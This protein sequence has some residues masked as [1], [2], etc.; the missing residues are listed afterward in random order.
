MKIFIILIVALIA[1]GALVFLPIMF[2]D[3]SSK[4]KQYKLWNTRRKS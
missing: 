4:W 2:E 3:V 1:T